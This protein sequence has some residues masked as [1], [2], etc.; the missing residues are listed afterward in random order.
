MKRA[1]RAVQMQPP[2]HREPGGAVV[3]CRLVERKAREISS[4][5]RVADSFTLHAGHVPCV[6]VLG[7]FLT[8]ALESSIAVSE[9]SDLIACRDRGRW[10]L[11]DL[12]F[13]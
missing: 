10:F 13:E 6:K 12:F 11:G 1:A 8:T 2:K 9:I 4:C 3:H 5:N 7:F